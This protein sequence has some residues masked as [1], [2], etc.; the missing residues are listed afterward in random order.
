[1]PAIR[2][3]PLV[4]LSWMLASGVALAAD[5]SA[6]AVP[7]QI[8]PQA[9]AAVPEAAPATVATGRLLAVP[10]G[11]ELAFEMVDSLSSKTSQRG[12]RFALKLTE[13]LTLD[14][15]LLVPAG[16]LAVGEVV[17]ADRAKAGGQAGELVLAARYLDW[18]GRQLPLRAF[19]TGLGRNRTD[20]A[21]GVMIAAGVA[22]FLVRGGQIEIAAGSPIT[23]TLREA[24]EL[25]VLAPVVTTVPATTEAD[26]ES[27]PTAVP[28][29]T[30]AIEA[31]ATTDAAEAGELPAAAEAAATPATPATTDTNDTIPGE[32]E[33]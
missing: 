32:T 29:A 27:A 8:P 31:R 16:T 6:T 14:G 26:G 23:A 28:G 2:P 24:V 15:Q 20:T 5:G 1:M 21:M 4:F 19:R 17:H 18:D 10:A 3:A 9:N 25:P 13:P 11:T 12:D 33:E 30:P 7:A 22:G